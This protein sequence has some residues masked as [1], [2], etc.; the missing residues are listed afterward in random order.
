MIAHDVAQKLSETPPLR[1]NLT[2]YGASAKTYEKLCGDGNAYHR[3]LQAVEFLKEYHIPVGLL[4]EEAELLS[5]PVKNC[6]ATFFAAPYGIS[7]EEGFTDGQVLPYL[8]GELMVIA[9]PGHTA[10]C[11]CYYGKTEGVLFAGDTLFAGSIGRTDLPTGN[12]K[13]LRQSLKKLAALTEDYPIYPGHEE[14][15]TLFTE[16]KRNPFLRG[17]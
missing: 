16:K 15:T 9:T 17:V 13:T 3:V 11:C 5:D 10:G 2:L 14:S 8:S 12:L 6:S 4:A 7:A 1:I